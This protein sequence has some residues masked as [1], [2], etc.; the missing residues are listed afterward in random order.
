[1]SACTAGFRRHF[2]NSSRI[3]TSQRSKGFQIVA[4]M[5]LVS[6][7]GAIDRFTHPRQVMAFLGGVSRER[8][9][10][11]PTT[12]A[13]N[14]K[15]NPAPPPRAGGGWAPLY[16]TPPHPSKERRR[17]R[18]GPKGRGGGGRRRGREPP[19][20]PLTRL[21]ARRLQRNKAIVA[22]ARELCGFIWE[23]LRTQACYQAQPLSS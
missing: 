9:P 19:P 7:L 12:A 18:G 11:R 22:I 21:M 5:I 23:L 16:T 4:A 8:K 20:P 10:P 17:R 3:A 14:K 6:E 15:P 2:S 13:K 1:M